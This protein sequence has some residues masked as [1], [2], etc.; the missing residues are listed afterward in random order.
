MSLYQQQP[1]RVGVHSKTPQAAALSRF[2]C[3]APKIESGSSMIHSPL[4]RFDRNLLMPDVESKT[5]VNTH[6][7]VRDPHQREQCEDESPPVR[8]QEFVTRKQENTRRNIMTEAE[9]ASE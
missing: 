2:W 6:V 5:T 1:S 8:Y 3:R 9:F 7:N 4:I